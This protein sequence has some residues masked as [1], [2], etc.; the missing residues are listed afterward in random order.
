[1]Y[2]LLGQ[3]RGEAT[4]SDSLTNFLIAAVEKEANEVLPGKSDLTTYEAEGL[5]AIPNLVNTMSGPPETVEFLA[6]KL[7]RAEPPPRDKY[8]DGKAIVLGTPF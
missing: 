3:A 1:M 5:W 7:A 8:P 2:H 4:Y 6:R